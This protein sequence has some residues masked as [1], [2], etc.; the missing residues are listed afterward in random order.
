MKRTG[1][2][3]VLFLCSTAWLATAQTVL[4]GTDGKVSLPSRDL[5]CLRLE[6]VR[7]NLTLDADTRIHGTIVDQTK[8]PFLK[9]PIELRRYISESEQVMVKKVRTDDKGNFDLGKVKSGAYR[10]LLSPGRGF[11][12]PEKLNCTAKKCS[13]DVVLVVNPTD[14][15][16]A[17]CPIR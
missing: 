14:S 13:L 16:T 1:C 8:A 4:V 2:V 12:Q 6:V 5:E 3:M 17:A 10:L 7:P 9:S 11:A 15:I